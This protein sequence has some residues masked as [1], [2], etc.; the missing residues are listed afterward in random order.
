MI[1]RESEVVRMYFEGA[2]THA[3][4]RFP[5]EFVLGHFEKTP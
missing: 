1:L 5:K 2:Q 3:P 4:K